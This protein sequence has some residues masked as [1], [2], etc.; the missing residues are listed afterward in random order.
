VRVVFLLVVAV[1]RSHRFFLR[2]E[3]REVK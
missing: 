2:K 1:L 3:R